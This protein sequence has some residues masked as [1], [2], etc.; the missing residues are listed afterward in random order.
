MEII[1]IIVI[2]LAVTALSAPKP[3]KKPVEW[4]DR[5]RRR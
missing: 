3:A 5:R 2:C 1:A 4:T